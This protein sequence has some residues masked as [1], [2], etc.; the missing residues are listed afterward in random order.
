M[1]KMLIPPKSL[2]GREKRMYH[3]FYNEFVTF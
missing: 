1:K 2:D 3:M